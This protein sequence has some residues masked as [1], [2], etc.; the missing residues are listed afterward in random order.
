[1]KTINK[2]SLLIVSILMF[3]LANNSLGNRMPYFVEVIPVLEANSEPVVFGIRYPAIGINKIFISYNFDKNILEHN[4]STSDFLKIR[5]MSFNDA[6]IEKPLEHEHHKGL[7]H[8]FLDN[9]NNCQYFSL[10]H[11][12]FL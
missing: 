12:N 8:Y 11:L 4:L 6:L 2:I 7:L 5:S 10:I 9:N 1:M 3:G